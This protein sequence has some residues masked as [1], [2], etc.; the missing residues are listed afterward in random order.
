[1]TAGTGTGP[2]FGAHC[3]PGAAEERLVAGDP[4]LSFDG[5]ADWDRGD[6]AWLPLRM[7]VDRLATAMPANF[8]W[9][10]RTTAEV[11]FAARTDARFLELEVEVGADP[12]GS[13]LDVRVDGAPWPTA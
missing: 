7:P 12:G 13:P 5:N 9:L 4:R 1:M 10:A 6:G 8:F 2:D 3:A 11:R